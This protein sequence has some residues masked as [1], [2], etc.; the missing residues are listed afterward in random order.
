MEVSQRR[1]IYSTCSSWCD[2][3]QINFIG[4]IFEPPRHK[5][6]NVLSN[7]TYQSVRRMARH[8]SGTPVVGE[9]Q[10]K[11]GSIRAS[12]SVKSAAR[13]CPGYPHGELAA[14]HI[15]YT[16]S[17]LLRYPLDGDVTFCPLGYH[18]FSMCTGGDSS[19]DK[20]MGIK[21]WDGAP[22]TSVRLKCVYTFAH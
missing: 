14:C 7:L 10:K 16:V 18:S 15:V 11:A 5:S 4:T 6:S 12:W 9:A 17:I 2:T 21:R 20:M 8:M 13:G 19:P 1:S 3:L 22:V